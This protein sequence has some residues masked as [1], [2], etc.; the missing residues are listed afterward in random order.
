MLTGGYASSGSTGKDNL[1]DQVRGCGA[2]KA[3]NFDWFVAPN[4]DNHK[5][6]GKDF[7]EH[8]EWRYHGRLPIGTRRCLG[9][10]MHTAGGPDKGCEGNG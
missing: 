4:D 8:W 1:H 5:E 7:G 6:S 3:D 9:R 10:A 2:V